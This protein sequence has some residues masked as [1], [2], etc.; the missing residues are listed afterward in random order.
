M[1]RE[2]TETLMDIL[3]TYLKSTLLQSTLRQ[4]LS[5]TCHESIIKLIFRPLFKSQVNALLCL[6]LLLFNLYLM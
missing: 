2:G 6:C 4:L 5:V 3:F 1:H